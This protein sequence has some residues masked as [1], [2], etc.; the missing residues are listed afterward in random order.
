[1]PMLK[2]QAYNFEGITN[3]K[4]FQHQS[5]FRS[6]YRCIVVIQCI[7]GPSSYIGSMILIIMHFS[8]LH[9]YSI[10]FPAIR[11]VL[12]RM[13]FTGD[14]F[15]SCK[16]ILQAANTNSLSISNAIVSCMPNHFRSKV[17][18]YCS[19]RPITLNL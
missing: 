12:V 19:G 3:T 16:E 1:M 2:P 6:M 15:R 18:G 9:P 13:T 4:L 10:R 8:K 5:L 17:F 14:A 7:L 11:T